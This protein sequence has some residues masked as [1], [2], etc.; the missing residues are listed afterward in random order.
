MLP[1]NPY[2]P[3]RVDPEVFPGSSKTDT[4]RPW[5]LAAL[6]F[7]LLGYFVSRWLQMPP[8][9]AVQLVALSIC[10]FCLAVATRERYS[11][12]GESVGEL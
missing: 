9:G 5:R 1:T 3:P 11:K 10:F 7:A 4:Q 12:R 6:L 2:S 8:L